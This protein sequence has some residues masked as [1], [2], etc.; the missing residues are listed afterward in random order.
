MA[1][2]FQTRLEAAVDSSQTV[3]IE[4]I[5]TSWVV[6]AVALITYYR[7]TAM[8]SGRQDEDEDEA[9]DRRGLIRDHGH[10]DRRTMCSN[11]VGSAVVVAWKLDERVVR[12]GTLLS[13][14][15]PGKRIGQ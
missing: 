12:G 11:R 4:W 5:A 1:E 15:S 3:R 8:K 9:D 10:R 13:S 2:V 14:L 7:F 6:L